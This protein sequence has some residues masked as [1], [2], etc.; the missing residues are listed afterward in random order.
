[1]RESPLLS[2]SIRF[3]YDRATAFY[4]YNIY[5]RDKFT[6]DTTVVIEVTVPATELDVFLTEL[7]DRLSVAEFGKTLSQIMQHERSQSRVRDV[8]LGHTSTLECMF[9]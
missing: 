2:A 1:M 4:I 3:A 7:I 5:S 8:K 6:A 9:L